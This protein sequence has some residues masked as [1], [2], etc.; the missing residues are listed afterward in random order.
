MIAEQIA[1]GDGVGVIVIRALLLLV[2]VGRIEGYALVDE[3]VPIPTATVAGAAHVRGSVP[4]IGIPTV[5]HGHAVHEIADGPAAVD[6]LG[7]RDGGNSGNAVEVLVVE[8]QI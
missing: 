2:R 1:Q 3:S 6:R 5:E 4:V 8:R 7:G